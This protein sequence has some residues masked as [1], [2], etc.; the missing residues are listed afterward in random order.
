MP[1]RAIWLPCA[2]PAQ[3]LPKILALFSGS[4]YPPALQRQLSE[5]FTPARMNL[6]CSTDAIARRS[7]GHPAKYRHHPPRLFRRTGSTSSKPRAMPGNGSPTW[8]P[9]SANAPASKPSR[10]ATTKSLAITSKSPTATPINAP[11][12]YIRKQTLVNAERYITPE[13]KEYETLVL[14]AEERI[15]EIEVRLFREVCASWPAASTA[16]AGNR[17]QPGRTGRAWPRWQKPPL[18]AGYVRPD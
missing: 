3:S 5:S 11:A 14:N 2:Q 15:H 10:S 7:A 6:T 9:S 16:L 8:K 4:R 18:L 17:P 13:M 12:D 1:C